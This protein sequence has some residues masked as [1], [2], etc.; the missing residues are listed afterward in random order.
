MLVAWLPLLLVKLR[1]P[2]HQHLSA[3][4]QP[5]LMMKLGVLCA[6]L[7]GWPRESVSSYF[8]VMAINMNYLEAFA[9]P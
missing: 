2:W 5:G 7:N 3:K 4:Q 6:I 9:R 1:L 8:R